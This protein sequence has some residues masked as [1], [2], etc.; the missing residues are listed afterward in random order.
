MMYVNLH[1]LLLSINS[2]FR[3]FIP[4]VAIIAP[5]KVK[6]QKVIGMGVFNSSKGTISDRWA[7]SVFPTEG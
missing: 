1:C 5:V 2:M 6:S 3:A 7:F 4:M